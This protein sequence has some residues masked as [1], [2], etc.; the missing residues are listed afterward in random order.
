MPLSDL[1]RRRV[2]L[3]AY[4]KTRAELETISNVDLADMGIKRYQLG[5]VAR[6]KALG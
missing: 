2:R 1:L 4:R 5:H 6:V 3:Q